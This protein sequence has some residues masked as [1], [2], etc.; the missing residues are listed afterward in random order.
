MK[1][2]I[3]MV[4]LFAMVCATAYAGINDGIV[5]AWS[6]DDGTAAD[7]SGRNPGIVHGAT[8]AA[9]MHG[10][11]LSFDGT[12][13]YV[14]VPDSPSLQLPEGLTVA[15]WMNLDAGGDHAAICWKGEMVGWGANF[16]FRV[17]TT[18][19]TSMTWGRCNDGEQ[20]FATGDVLP[21]PGEWIHV[22][23]T[24]MAP[25]APTTQRAYVNGE[26]ITDVTGQTGQIASEGPFQVFEGIPVEMGVGRGIGG[27]VG[28]DTYFDGLIDDVIIYKRG[29]TADEIVELMDLDVATAVESS[30]K[31]ATVWGAIKS[32]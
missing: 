20:Y 15:A 21:G 11:C 13:D 23:M 14:E 10:G 31:E 17:C 5:S 2:C 12:D 3:V 1:K 26:D 9:G 29:L 28:N 6:F 30:G 16:S 22:A 25:G 18:N 27:T 4:A 19:D 32:Q 8:L 7:Q 24:C